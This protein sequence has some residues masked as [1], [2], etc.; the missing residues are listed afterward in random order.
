MVEI[1]V[2]VL[3][4]SLPLSVKYMYMSYLFPYV[5]FFNV[6][7]HISGHKKLQSHALHIGNV[8]YILER[9]CYMLLHIGTLFCYHSWKD[10][11]TCYC[12]LAH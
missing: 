1:S 4:S 6:T 5:R 12:I 9:H 8:I 2:N 11:V 10:I 3:V 7:L